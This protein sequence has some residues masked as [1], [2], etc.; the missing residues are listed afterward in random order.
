MPSLLPCSA[1]GRSRLRG[2]CSA[3]V[4]LV[5]LTACAESPEGE[6]VPATTAALPLSGEEGP[7]ATE[8]PKAA[9][10]GSAEGPLSGRTVLIDPGHNGGN[11]EAAEEINRQVD[12]GPETKACDTVG[13]ATEDGYTESAFNLDLSERL[14]DS[15]EAEGALVVLTREDDEGVGPCIDERAEIGNEAEADAAVSIHAD[16]G[17]PTGRGFHVI[18]PEEVP[19]YTEDITEPSLRL[20]EEVR[21]AFHEGAGIPYADYIGTEGLDLRGDLGGL[22]LSTVPKIFLEA[23]NM[24]NSED[25]ELLS[26]EEW[27]DQAAEAVAE[28][29]AGF[30]EGS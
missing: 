21:D 8:Q 2:P 19:G 24:R 28:G 10:P 13:A 9:D 12:A 14:R 6:P 11:A 16:G 1:L 20:A 5:S 29:V 26:D 22:N 15:L 27:Q 7:G 25:A 30:L 4:L 23:G 18:A 3:A 17:P